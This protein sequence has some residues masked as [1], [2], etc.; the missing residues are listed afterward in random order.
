MKLA[1]LTITNYGC[2]D[3]QGY[4]ITIDKI[5][6]LIG[7]NNAGKSTV[8]DAYES[9][10]SAGTALPI[11]RFHKLDI[12]NKPEII[13]LFSDV[14]AV[15]IETIGGAYV[16][17][18]P[19]KGKCVKV[20]WRWDTPGVAGKKYSYSQDK[21]DWIEGGVG[22]WDSLFT[23]R[24]PKALRIRPTD[25]HEAQEKQIKEILTASIKEA[26]KN[27]TSKKESVFAQLQKLTDELNISVKEELGTACARISD[28]LKK[29]FEG[30]EVSFVP[31]TA[32]PDIEKLLGSDSYLTIQQ[33]GH[34]AVRLAA[35]GTG[36]Q[37]AFLWS[38][39][40]ALAE[41]GHG[42]KK[43]TVAKKTTKKE[44]EKEVDA[45]P[46]EQSRIL[47][48]DEPESFLHPPAIRAARDS[49]YS[50][51]EQLASWQVLA[52]THSPVFIDVSKPH[53]SIV[54]VARDGQLR[55]RC[56]STDIACFDEDER[57]QLQMIRSCHP[58]VNEFFFAD[59]VILVEGETEHAVLANLLAEAGGKACGKDVHIVNCLGKANIPMFMRILK[60]FRV[61]Y[62]VVHDSD[63]PRN[64]RGKN[65]MWSI[66]ESILKELTAPVFRI[67]HIPNFE[68]YYFNEEL[69]GNKPYYA[70]KALA[71]NDTATYPKLDELRTLA[72]SIVDGT[73][74]CKTGDHDHLTQRVKDY[75]A[76]NKLGTAMAWKFDEVPVA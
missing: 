42:D 22:G 55:S 35:Q 13:G 21:G 14:T 57:K 68:G 16:F 71:E 75:V 8:L 4:E 24:I 69:S 20:K 59:H 43:K 50:L 9:Y 53:T 45:K 6:V 49:L 3:A 41:L 31:K 27:D 36:L 5:V 2:I 62:T 18:D 19:K 32:T 11:E 60:Q 1:N 39:I 58:T 33:S 30:H 52:S 66:N 7:P 65:A 34:T 76:T 51:V 17:E 70:L 40:A 44:A 73:H 46:A 72:T 26:L 56:F 12:A 10:A 29:T 48:I 37:R 61:E 63:S 74:S 15:D 28:K 38:A 54:R 23:S 64:K 47:L 25:S 67:V